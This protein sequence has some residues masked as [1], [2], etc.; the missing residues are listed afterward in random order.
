MLDKSED[1]DPIRKELEQIWHKKLPSDALPKDWDALYA[2]IRTTAMAEEQEAP[3]VVIRRRMSGIRWTAAAVAV[4]IAG[5]GLYTWLRPVKPSIATTAPVPTPVQDVAPGGNKA[6]LMLDDGSK[7]ILDDADNGTLAT[8]GNASI[9]KTDSGQLVYRV[10][11][12]GDAPVTY[13]TLATP[14]GGQFQLCLPDRT[15]VWLNAASSIRYPTVF[16]GKERRV[17]IT[18]EVYFEVSPLYAS[19]GRGGA[20]DKVPFI[21]RINKETEI[22]V[23][24]THFNV[25]AYHDEAT[26]KATLLE[27]A[28]QVKHRQAGVV[29]KPGQQAQVNGEH[30]GTRSTDVAPAIKIVNDADISQV[31]AW[32]DGIFNF[33]RASLQD[34]MR[35]LSR[36]YDIDVVYEHG[37]PE[38]EFGGKMGRDVS[39][40]K[41][42]YFFKGSDVHFR[43][44]GEGKKLIVTQ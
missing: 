18:G 17:E 22:A 42:L 15:K 21:V 40:A 20:K 11:H 35:Q 30:A 8:Q 23:L 38:M 13:N 5:A 4:L 37:V 28:V 2:R 44:E 14:R 29:L 33:H 31:M 43:I 19:P 39:L 6:T 41:V 36:W 3:V 26:I 27:G 9:V 32:K 10:A 34:V 16:N 1:A 25:N 12:P 7:I 24:G